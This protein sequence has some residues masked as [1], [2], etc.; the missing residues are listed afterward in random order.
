MNTNVDPSEIKKFETLAHRWWD[1]D[2]EFR[3][4]HQINPLRINYIESLISLDDKNILDVG[5]GG[6]ILAE[7]LATKGAHV[8]GIDMADKGLGVAKLHLHES[9]LNITYEKSSAEDYA[10][11]HQGMFDVVT[12]MEMLE[13]VPDP[14]SVVRACS[15]LVK[16]GGWVV[17]S[18]ISKTPK[19][20]LFAIVGAEHI[21]R[22]L[23]KGTHEYKKFI[24][25]STLAKM[26]LE[27]GLEVEKT[28]G[29][30]YNPITRVYSLN[31]QLDVNYILVARKSN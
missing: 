24:K 30:G 1:P 29:M 18:T 12:C 31:D 8:T 16:P 28:K 3:P 22:L 15:E 4:L 2:G 11:E 19:A 23:P 6:G 20:F 26:A 10:G 5:C 7:G 27:S 13:H 14:G 9:K 25:P 21:L 17:F